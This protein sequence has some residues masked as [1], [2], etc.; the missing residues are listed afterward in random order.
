[1]NLFQ[2]AN[3]LRLP[4]INLFP[5]EMDLCLWEIVP[6]WQA[7]DQFLAGIIPAPVEWTDFCTAMNFFREEKNRWLVR[8]IASAEGNDFN[9]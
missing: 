2:N 7:A 1:M 9:L 3:K 4:G 5:L 8:T 6:C